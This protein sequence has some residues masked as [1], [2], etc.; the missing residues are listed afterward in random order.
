MNSKDLMLRVLSGKPLD[1]PPVVLHSWGAYKIGLAGINP[2]YLYYLGGPEL[3]EI[4]RQFYERFKPDWMHL[5]SGASKN[6]WGRSRKVENNRAFIQSEDGTHWMEILDN[7][8]LAEGETYSKK[9]DKKLRL[10]SKAEIDDYFAST[11][12]SEEDILQSGRFEHVSILTKEYGDQVFIAIN[13]GAPGCSIPGYSFEEMMIACVEKPSLVAYYIYKS[14]EQFLA[15]VRAAKACGAHAYIFSEGFGGSLDNLSPEMHEVIELDAKVWFYSEV[16]KTGVLPI[17]Y[18]LGDVRPNMHL[19]NRLDMAAL[20]IEE[21][22]KNFT[23]DP[24]EV[25]RNLRADICLIGN[26]DS[27]LLLKGTPEQIRLEVHRQLQAVK[28]GAFILAN[29]SPLIIGTPPAN[30]ETFVAEGK[31][32][33]KINSVQGGNLYE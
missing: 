24:V 4:E 2:K 22:K 11:A 26:L 1:P 31:S 18:W 14:C 21:S 6:W 17:G 8:L 19:I 29:G 27:A 5:G 3:A 15:D 12:Y 28:H 7:Y 20:M 9:P 23:L 33:L 32:G 10:E 30:I 13:D 25:R 16:R